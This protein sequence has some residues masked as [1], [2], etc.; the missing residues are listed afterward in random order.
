[1]VWYRIV[2]GQVVNEVKAKKMET[3]K[4]IKRLQVHK[5]NLVRKQKQAKVDYD[6]VRTSIPL[7]F[8]AGCPRKPPNGRDAVK[9][10]C[11]CQ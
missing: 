8:V 3:M 1:M 4:G 7:Q 11:G 6:K 9:L 10:L 5:E 2:C